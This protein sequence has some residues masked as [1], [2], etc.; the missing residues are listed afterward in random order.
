MSKKKGT[1]AP[2]RLFIRINPPGF[3]SEYRCSER[4]EDVLSYSGRD[5]VHEYRYVGSFLGER[6]TNLITLIE[7]DETS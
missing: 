1:K 5:V 3:D 7:E 6:Q 2:K 4:A